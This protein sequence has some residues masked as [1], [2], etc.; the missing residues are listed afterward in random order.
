MT[1]GKNKKMKITKIY[2]VFAA[3]PS[4]SQ[5]SR[6]GGGGGVVVSRQNSHLVKSSSVQV[7]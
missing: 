7:E 2:L 5:D 4:R 1:K 3:A 6:E